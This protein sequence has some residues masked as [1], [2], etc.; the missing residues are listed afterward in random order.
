MRALGLSDDAIDRARAAGRLHPVFRGVFAVGHGRIGERGRMMAAVLACGDGS[1]VSHRSAAVLL[2][3]A[4]RAPVVVDAI[5][6][7]PGRGRKIDG[8]RAHGVP[9]PTPAERGSADGIPCTSPARTLVDL[10]GTVRGR[11]LRAGFERAA[12]DG[13]LDLDAVEAAARQ[14][15]RP[16]TPLVLAIAAEWRAAT[17]LVPKARLRS[18]FEARLLP[19]LAATDLP[20]PQVNAPVQTPGGRLEVDLLWPDHRF[21]VE[22]DSRRHHGTEI[23]FERD[24]RRDRELMRAG[25]KTLRPTWRQVEREPELVLD[26]I[27]RELDARGG[28][29][30]P[31]P[32]SSGAPRS[33]AR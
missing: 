18:P 7:A 27:L 8:V 14:R 33:P 23:A 32:R 20:A 17:E 9:V 26:A 6:S 22:A 30:G 1:V 19:L 29:S 16:G 3:L 11:T 13:A 28:P 4:D 5:A 10:A 2:G 24:R 12:A 25:Y 21:V 15:P 31:G